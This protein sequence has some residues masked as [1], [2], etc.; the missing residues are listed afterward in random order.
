MGQYYRPLLIFKDGT[1]CLC[2]LD[3]EMYKNLV[4]VL[5]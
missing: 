2:E 5:Y 4:A 3:N 1:K